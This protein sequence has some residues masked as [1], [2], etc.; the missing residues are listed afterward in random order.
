MQ[1]YN[2]SIPQKNIWNLQTFYGD[3]AVANICGAVIFKDARDTDLMEKALNKVI[4]NQT[5]LRLHFIERFGDVKQYVAEYTYV[6]IPVKQFKNEAEFENYASKCA[7]TPIGLLDRNMYRFEIVCICGKVGVLVALS[8]LISDAWTFSLLVR[9]MDKAYQGLVGNETENEKA[10]D[11][12]TYVMTEE[13]YFHSEKYE[14]DALY[15]DEK[16]HEKPEKCYMKPNAT[17]AK[18]INAN[19]VIKSLSDELSKHINEFCAKN[20]ITLPV[21]FETA[22]SIY[23]HK[24]NVENHSITIGLPVLN[25]NKLSEKNTAGM[26]ISTMPLT[27]VVSENDTVEQLAE[28]IA[29]THTELF[30]HQKYPYSKILQNLRE[31]QKLGGGGKSL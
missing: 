7:V 19:R 14:K 20:R 25:R 24:I 3:T 8:H 22:L 23:L 13:N 11:Y 27:V 4:K 5:A 18:M 10:F 21:L 17:Q 29:N 16:Y 15:W 12:I 28:R 6:N 9:E 2:L 30:R 26:F 1:C 31:N